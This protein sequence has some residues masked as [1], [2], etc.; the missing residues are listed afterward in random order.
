MK[1]RVWA[2]IG[3]QN[4]GKTTVIRHLIS[5]YILTEDNVVQVS[6]KR[7]RDY[8]NVLL[9]GGGTLK[10]FVRVK[11]L[12]EGDDKTRYTPQEFIDL[13][14]KEAKNI[15]DTKDA[16]IRPF[17]FNVLVS[18]RSDV[19]VKGYPPAYSYLSKF[20]SVGWQ[21]ESLV[22]LGPEGE[23]DSGGHYTKKFAAP[24][25]GRFG[26]PVLFVHDSRRYLKDNAIADKD[27]RFLVQSLV[28]RVRNH[29]GWA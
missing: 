15:G 9:R 19:D 7:A 29:F 26:A 14:H 4:S 10:L 12:Q 3:G 23:P 22:L 2:I 21:L 16:S 17:Y 13:V 28:G 11:S 20:E 8:A 18:I 24:L 6:K 5:S 1:I 25:H 27:N